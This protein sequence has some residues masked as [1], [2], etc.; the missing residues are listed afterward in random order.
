[1]RIANNVLMQLA[2]MPT[3]EK[4]GD[5]EVWGEFAKYYKDA[6]NQMLIS[7]SRSIDLAGL[8]PYLSGMS[9]SRLCENMNNPEVVKSPLVTTGKPIN[10]CG[11]EDCYAGNNCK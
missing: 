6:L 4:N 3:R 9:R 11:D 1:F 5:V 8:Q 7:R 10:V 2:M